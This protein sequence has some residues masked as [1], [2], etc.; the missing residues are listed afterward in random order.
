MSTNIF[1]RTV[2]ACGL[3][4]MS[5]LVSANV[6][7]V[8]KRLAAIE[9]ENE[10]CIQEA[11]GGDPRCQGV[12]MFKDACVKR[13]SAKS[14]KCRDEAIRIVNM[15]YPSILSAPAD[16][17]IKR[18]EMYAPLAKSC[19]KHNLN[20]VSDC[21]QDQYQIS[22]KKYPET[23]GEDKYFGSYIS[24]ERDAT[25]Q[26][27]ISSDPRLNE[28]IEGLATQYVLEHQG[29]RMFG[30]W[31]AY[32]ILIPVAIGFILLFVLLITWLARVAKR[33]RALELAMDYTVNLDAMTFARCDLK[34]SVDREKGLVIINEYSYP[35]EKFT[36]ETYETNE[37]KAYNTGGNQTVY[38]SGGVV[39]TVYVPG[40]TKT[41]NKPSGYSVFICGHRFLF[42]YAWKCQP[43]LTSDN[44]INCYNAMVEKS[45]SV[46]I[47]VLKRVEQISSSKSTEVA[48][49]L[50]IQLIEKAGICKDCIYNR[51]YD[52][53]LMKLT[54]AIAVDKTG[55]AVVVYNNGAGTWMGSLKGATAQVVN[56]KL[57][58]KVDDPAYREKHLAE[59]RFS[60]LEGEKREVLVE[61]EDRINMLAKSAA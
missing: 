8:A 29:T 55:K 39:G 43:T 41:Y 4:L 26:D 14:L 3:L 7:Q 58:L 10:R 52:P 60:L 25:I 51:S 21:K 49:G 31:V 50:F 12:D 16:Q 33:E 30:E 54:Q 61:W 57:E 11:V 5:G 20:R 56:N 34:F 46:L 22:L 40:E 45:Y 38:G 44:K 13:A 37:V 47:E 53:Q 15:Q 42:E 28:A 9:V 59:R 32:N 19:E 23:S 27:E 2:I 1:I 18:F 17:L 48:E 6:E 36:Y 24:L 35:I